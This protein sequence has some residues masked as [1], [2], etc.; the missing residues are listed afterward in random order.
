MKY[1]FLAFKRTFDVNGKSS[2]EEFWYFFLID[3]VILFL[4][5]LVTGKI[6]DKTLADAI[7]FGYLIIT[8]IP[9]YTLGFRRLN[10]AG[11]NKYLFFIPVLN[12][13]FAS[14]ESKEYK[15]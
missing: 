8:I 9:F 1:Y 15:T 7:S 3:L 6:S 5:G 4:I 10:D 13:L 2:K 11:Y 12:L 14:M